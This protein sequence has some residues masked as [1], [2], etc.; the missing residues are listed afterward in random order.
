[1][2]RGCRG[3]IR[4]LRRSQR[5]RRPETND[6]GRKEV[7]RKQLVARGMW[8]RSIH[9]YALGQRAALQMHDSGTYE[10][11]LNIGG[12][13]AEL[14]DSKVELGRND[15]A[16]VVWIGELVVDSPVVAPASKGQSR[17]PDILNE[18]RITCLGP[19]FRKMRQAMHVRA[20][21]LCPRPSVTVS[22][23]GVVGVTM[24]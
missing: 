1:M 16:G 17:S 14:V 12:F 6:V 8:A 21:A 13:D 10:V 9:S 5:T 20:V 24:A 18:A 22:V 3:G 2:P 11:L 4:A 7:N 15:T 23:Q 19:L